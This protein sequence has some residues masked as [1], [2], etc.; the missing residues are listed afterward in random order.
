VADHVL[1]AIEA[2][3]R[4]AAPAM[5]ATAHISSAEQAAAWPR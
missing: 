4:A 1:A 2:V 3:G 5:I